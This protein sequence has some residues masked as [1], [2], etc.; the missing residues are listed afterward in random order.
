[1]LQRAK[2]VKLLKKLTFKS[3]KSGSVC[4]NGESADSMHLARAASLETS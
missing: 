2:Q 4:G 1:M 3:N